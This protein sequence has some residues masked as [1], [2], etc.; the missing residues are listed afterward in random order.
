LYAALAPSPETASV[1]KSACRTWEDQ[2]WAEI[3]I[4]CEEKASQELAQLGGSFWEG[5]AEAVEKGVQDTPPKQDE[6]NWET[7]VSATL[8]NLKGV[9]VLE[10]Y[11]MGFSFLYIRYTDMI[12][13]LV[14][15]TLSMF[16]S[17]ILSLTAQNCFWIF[18]QRDLK[19]ERILG[20]PLSSFP[21]FPSVKKK[22]VKKL[23]IS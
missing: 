7:E 6:G 15:I 19:M 21:F 11:V 18:L 2:L 14:Q 8:D 10:G 4:I 22:I 23:T 20:P 1:L 17:F 12:K 5:G 9:A 13:A 3:S 16:H